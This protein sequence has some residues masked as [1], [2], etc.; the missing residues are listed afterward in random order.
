[1]KQLIAFAFLSLTAMAA[2]AGQTIF[3]PDDGV[4]CDKKAG[5]CADKDGIAV[6]HTE[7]YLGK[8]AAKKLQDMISS[9]GV[10]SFDATSF[11]MSNGMH[12]ET[13][14]K[15]CTT[16]KFNDKPDPVGNTTLFG[17]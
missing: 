14:E 9:V 13:R 17:K 16:S 10:D 6:G 5:F 11:T 12:C 2:L 3:S 1:M 7:V 4:L 8:K 15:N